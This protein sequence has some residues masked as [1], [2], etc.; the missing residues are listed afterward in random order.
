M[1]PEYASPE[2][3]RGA[4]VTKTTDIYSLG[5]LLYELLSG[6]GR[7]GMVTILRSSG[8]VYNE[9]PVKPSVAAGRVDEEASQDDST[10]TV[11]TPQLVAEARAIRPKIYPLLARRS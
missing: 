7:T 8:D 3:A 5:V 11:I 10:R 4:P 6:I 2:Q 1:T 9:E